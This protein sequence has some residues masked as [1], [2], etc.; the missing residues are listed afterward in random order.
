MPP[1]DVRP[2]HGHHSYRLIRYLVVG[3][4]ACAA[5]L[6]VVSLYMWFVARSAEPQP[7][8]YLSEAEKMDL[9][10]QVAASSPEPMVPVADRHSIL[11]SVEESGSAYGEE[12]KL[13]IL[14]SI[15]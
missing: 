2:D 5:A 10:M 1:L 3:S 4:F 12:Q 11:E 8:A 6:A 9:L 13:R 15:Q 7:E 14:E